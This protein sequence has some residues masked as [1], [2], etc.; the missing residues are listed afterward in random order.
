MPRYIFLP[1]HMLPEGTSTIGAPLYQYGCAVMLEE[2]EMT[3]IEAE[4]FANLLTTVTD[5][6]YTAWQE[7]IGDNYFVYRVAVNSEKQEQSH[8]NIRTKLE[9]AMRMCRNGL[10]QL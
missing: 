4:Y 9:N 6:C 5:D 2:V 8:G 7:G 1:G 3:N 10:A